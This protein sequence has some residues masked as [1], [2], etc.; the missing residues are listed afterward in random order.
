MLIV[1]KCFIQIFVVVGRKC[2]AS[3]NILLRFKVII[4]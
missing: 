4:L 3:L 1:F 2:E